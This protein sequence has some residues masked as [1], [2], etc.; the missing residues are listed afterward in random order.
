MEVDNLALNRIPSI[1]EVQ[2]VNF[3]IDA[4]SV[5]SPNGFLSL[6]DQHYWNNMYGAIIDFFDGH[7]LQKGFAATSI[8]LLP[9]RK[10]ACR[11]T[12]YQSISLHTVFNKLIIKLLNTKLRLLLPHII[13]LSRVDLSPIALLG[14]LWTMFC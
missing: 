1:N 14:L 8:I 3:S 2:E 13:S 4:N 5:R 7:H 11:W 10:N 6:F 12:D 9:K